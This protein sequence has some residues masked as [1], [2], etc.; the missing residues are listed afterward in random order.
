MQAENGLLLHDSSP[1]ERHR[2]NPP[3]RQSLGRFIWHPYSV[4]RDV[5][6][7]VHVNMSS[8]WL[9]VCK[10]FG[11]RKN[12][13]LEMGKLGNN[14]H[15]DGPERGMKFGGLG[16]PCYFPPGKLLQEMDTGKNDLNS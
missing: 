16:V 7:T 5:R 9:A 13:I 12:R 15:V 14:K 6:I 4:E 1:K 2:R 11:G 8:K 3:S 10:E